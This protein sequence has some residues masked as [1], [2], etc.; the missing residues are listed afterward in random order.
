MQLHF[1]NSELMYDVIEKSL[2]SAES[3][4]N[5][6]QGMFATPACM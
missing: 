1:R 2:A 6:G 4:S 3:N 5:I